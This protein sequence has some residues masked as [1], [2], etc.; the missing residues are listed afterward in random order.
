MIAIDRHVAIRNRHLAFLADLAG[1]PA[2]GGEVVGAKALVRWRSPTRGFIPPGSF[3]PILEDIGLNAWL[4]GFVLDR[5]CAQW[6]HGTAS[7]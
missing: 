4:T 6:Q 3:L 5:A 7:A 1:A 2:A